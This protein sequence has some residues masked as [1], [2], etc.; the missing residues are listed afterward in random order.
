MSAKKMACLL[1][2]LIALSL[3]GCGRAEQAFKEGFKEKFDQ[4]C[5][6]GASKNG[7]NKELATKLCTCASD[8]LTTTLSSSELFELRN[9]ETP[10]AQEL[11]KNTIN[12][13]AAEHLKK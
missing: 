9:P 3:Q 13:C 11:L 2:G 12:A 4:N 10:K 6:E 1:A 8:K 5:I 7:G